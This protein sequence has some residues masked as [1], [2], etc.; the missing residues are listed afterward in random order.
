MTSL[1]GE[2]NLVNVS[3]QSLVSSLLDKSNLLVIFFTF[4]DRFLHMRF[5]LASVNLF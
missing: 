2:G 4:S 3:K 5:S 1:N